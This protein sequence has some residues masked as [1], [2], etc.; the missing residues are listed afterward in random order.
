MDVSKNVSESA[1]DRRSHQASRDRRRREQRA[2]SPRRGGGDGGGDHSDDNNARRTDR[3]KRREADRMQRKVRRS[4]SRDHDD[5]GW[6]RLPSGSAAARGATGLRDGI[7]DLVSRNRDGRD[8]KSSN[9]S[10]SSSGRRRPSTKVATGPAGGDIDSILVQFQESC[11]MHVAALLELKN[12]MNSSEKEIS[13]NAEKEKEFQQIRAWYDALAEKHTKL[14]KEHQELQAE[15]VALQQKY[16]TLTGASGQSSP[17]AANNLNESFVIE[18]R[19][20]GI[21][22][23]A[24][25]IDKAKLL[26]KKEKKEKK[27]KEK[28]GPVA[29]VWS[30][31]K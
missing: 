12:S 16:M 30:R 25:V 7:D 15:H 9:G 20:E 11:D 8:R 29:I 31:G 1:G 27:K 24:N 28:K 10:V 26:K 17:P 3:R 21:G 13:M 23:E 22:S 5:V 14:Q 6:G 4:S 19:I 2:A 18:G